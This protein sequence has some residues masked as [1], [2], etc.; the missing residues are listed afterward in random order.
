MITHK[1]QLELLGIIAKEMPKDIECYAFGGT[2][3]MFYGYKEE[4]KDIDIL[5]EDDNSRREFISTIR[6]LGFLETN[7]LKVYIPEK[8]REKNRPLMFKRGDFRFDLF[9]SRIFR[10][11]ISDKMKEDLYA[12][13]DFKE[14]KNLRIKVLRTEHIVLLKAIT[15]R[16]NDFD[17]IRNI[18]SKEKDFDWQYLVDEAVWQHKHGDS[19]VLIDLERTLKELKEYFFVPEKYFRQVYSAQGKK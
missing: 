13:H 1:D 19:W 12:I 18:I 7:L 9:V 4:T 11:Q 17:D 3:M 10:T 5:F 2:A 16:Q 6:K 8:L 14:K 15:E